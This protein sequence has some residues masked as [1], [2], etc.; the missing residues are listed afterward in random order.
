MHEFNIC[1]VDDIN[2]TNLLNKSDQNDF[3]NYI[4]KPL[5]KIKI[6]NEK[7]NQRN[8]QKHKKNHHRDFYLPVDIIT[9]SNDEQWTGLCSPC[10]CR[11]GY[12]FIYRFIHR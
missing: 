3:F 4:N 7:E 9:F 1:G 8:Y 6:N 12:S 10:R 5:Q 2:V 11:Y